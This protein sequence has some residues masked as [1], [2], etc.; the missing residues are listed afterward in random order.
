MRR[1]QNF[2]VPYKEHDR[3]SSNEEKLAKSTDFNLLER[4]FQRIFRQK[5]DDDDKRKA[6]N[7]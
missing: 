5:V 1:Y 7:Q 4:L 6:K 3:V 2:V